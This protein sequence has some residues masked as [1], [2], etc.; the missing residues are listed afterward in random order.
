MAQSLTPSAHPVPSGDREVLEAEGPAP[1]GVFLTPDGRLPGFAQRRLD[2]LIEK[3]K[4]SRLTAEE[5]KDLAE[6][7]DYI[8]AKSIQLLEY[9]AAVRPSKAPDASVPGG[10]GTGTKK[11]VPNRKRAQK[12]TAG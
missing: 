2:Y 5:K 1:L 10:H 8:D 4:K 11:P 3:K 6:A 7:L 12:K 9:A